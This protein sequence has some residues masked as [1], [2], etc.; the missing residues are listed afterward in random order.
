L[1]ALCFERGVPARERKKVR[2]L[3]ERV[4]M[5]IEIPESAFDAFTV[6]YS[7][8]HGYHALAALAAAGRKAGLDRKTALAAAAHALA[9]GIAYW[10]ESGL[11][12][13]DLLHEAATPGGVAAATMTAMDRAGYARVIARGLRAGIVQAR[14]NAR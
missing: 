6:T 12:A 1:T 2:A 4:G 5:V 14:R 11:S 3:F 9:D 13:D 10:R 8:S 7:S